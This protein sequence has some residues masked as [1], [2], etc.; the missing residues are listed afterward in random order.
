MKKLVLT[1]FFQVLLCGM[2]FTQATLSLATV[3]GAPESE[4][5]VSVTASGIKD[6]A[7]FKF[8]ISYDS[9]ILTYVRSENWALGVSVSQV[10][11][12]SADGKITFVYDNDESSFSINSGKFF[13]LVFEVNPNTAG[14]APLN[15]IDTPVP[16]ELLNSSM[17]IIDCTYSNGKVNIPSGISYEPSLSVK[18][19]QYNHAT[20]PYNYQLLPADSRGYVRAD[21][22]MNFKDETNTHTVNVY[23]KQGK[24]KIFEYRFNSATNKME[25]RIWKTI[26]ITDPSVVFFNNIVTIKDVILRDNI[27]RTF[28]NEKECYYVLIDRGA[29]S[30]GHPTNPKYW[31]GI[32][33]PD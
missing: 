18:N 5:S 25:G 9:S 21:L 15:W 33:S 24:I 26:D 20:A 8:T 23:P 32:S 11:I 19:P 14:F 13:D 22:S 16:R 17:N 31:D 7:T 3:T 2:A 29:I 10:Q 4:V 1:F 28:G 27:N 6:M 12:N 30:N